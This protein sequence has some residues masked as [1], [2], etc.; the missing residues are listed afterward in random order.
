M[1]IGELLNIS[2][3]E[4]NDVY[5]AQN[6]TSIQNIH[7]TGVTEDNFEE[8]INKMF[9]LNSKFKLVIIFQVIPFLNMTGTDWTDN[10]VSLV[11]NG[12][13]VPVTYSNRLRFCK[14]A[15]NQR[16]HEM[17]E[18]IL[19]VRRGLAAIVPFPLLTFQ[20]AENLERMI[21]G[22]PNISIPVLKTI[23]R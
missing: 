22:L 21:C 14:L 12:H 3:I 4:E 15:L 20:T 1:I 18:Q 16:F 5:Y 19:A 10:P 7:Q 2:D 23:V 6:L 9:K 17:D 11:P 13:C 8:V